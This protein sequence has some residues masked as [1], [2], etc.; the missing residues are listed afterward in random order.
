M[1]LLV[2]NDNKLK[3]MLNK[4][5]MKKHGLDGKELD[6]ED[7]ETRKRLFE[8]LDAVKDKCGFDTSLDKLLIQLYPS[9]DGGGE[10]FVTKLGLLSASAEQSL[11]RSRGVG[12]FCRDRE[13]YFF[14]LFSSLLF[15]SS[16]CES[17]PTVEQSLL[18]YEEGKGYY[19]V[20]ERKGGG[21][22][23]SSERLLEFGEPIHITR[24]GYIEEYSSLL[25]SDCAL[26]KLSSL[27]V[28]A[29]N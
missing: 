8:I 12:V 14:D 2:I 5:D 11:R 24:L 19:L 22:L 9:R 17:D 21:A 10:L 7:N 23:M 16:F 4:E 3:I 6:Y 28:K 18:Y 1:E 15:A 29:V 27:F 13:I 26:E 20:I 25:L